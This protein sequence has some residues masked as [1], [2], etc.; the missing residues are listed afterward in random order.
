MVLSADTDRNVVV[1]R[2]F[3][4]FIRDTTVTGFFFEGIVSSPDRAK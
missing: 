2:P 3:L 1:D 4:F